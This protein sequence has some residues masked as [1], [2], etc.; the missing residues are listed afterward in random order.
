MTDTDVIF[1]KPG[2][3]TI[4]SRENPSHI[5]FAWESFDIPLDDCVNAFAKAER[6]MAERGVFHIITNTARVTQAL[7]PEV[8]KWWGEVCM[9][10]LARRGVTLIVSVVPAAAAQSSTEVFSTIVMKKAAS[11]D[12]AESLVRAFSKEGGR[13]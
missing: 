4:T 12:E 5:Y 6:A 11:V 2:F 3:L 10:S 8:A 13:G 9:P 1:S 7:R